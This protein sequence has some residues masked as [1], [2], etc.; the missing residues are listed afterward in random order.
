[1]LTEHLTDTV[2][3]EVLKQCELSIVDLLHTS[4]GQAS[5]TTV[6]RLTIATGTL[7]RF[8]HPAAPEFRKLI[9]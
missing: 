7:E 2:V 8:E 5:R 9:A 4:S 1:M 3:K 6:N